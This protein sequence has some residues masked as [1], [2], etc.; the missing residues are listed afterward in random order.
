MHYLI[1]C[2]TRN[3]VIIAWEDFSGGLNDKVSVLEAFLYGTS[4]DGTDII[5][6]YG[7]YETGVEKLCEIHF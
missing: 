4:I 7:D 3:G 2:K 5:E 1:I 6:I